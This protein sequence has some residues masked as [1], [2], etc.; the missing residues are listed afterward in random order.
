[1]KQQTITTTTTTTTTP[2]PL[3]TKKYQINI[4]EINISPNLCFV[5]FFKKK[6]GILGS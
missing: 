3:F 6:I 2:S 4:F 1:M 5:F